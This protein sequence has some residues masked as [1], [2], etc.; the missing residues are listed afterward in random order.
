M[1]KNIVAGLVVVAWIVLGSL[2]YAQNHHR[3]WQ[4]HILRHWHA[5]ALKKT[6]EPCGS[7]TPAV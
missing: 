6:N 1:M 3:C 4:G 2:S 7:V 5:H